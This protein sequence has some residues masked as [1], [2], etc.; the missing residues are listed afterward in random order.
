M[1]KCRIRNAMI[2]RQKGIIKCIDKKI[3]GFNESVQIKKKLHNTPI[4]PKHNY[5]HIVDDVKCS[6]ST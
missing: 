4:G 5:N 2:W 3:S 6:L 1:L